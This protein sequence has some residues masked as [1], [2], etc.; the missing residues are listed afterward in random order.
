MPSGWAASWCPFGKDG[1]RLWVRETW[2]K[3]GEVGDEDEYRADNPDP[4]GA[5]WRSS[6][7]MPRSYCRLILE[8]FGSGIQKLDSV[9]DAEAI[10]EGARHFPDL[11]LHDWHRDPATAPRWS[12]GEPETTGDCMETPAL[13]FANYWNYRFGKGDG[14]PDHEAWC[15]A[16]T[17]RRLEATNA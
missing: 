1:D 5:R 9:T 3:A 7:S 11:P 14:W 12:M 17:V 6:T 8:V 4:L 10:A 2:A 13:A 16:M 15:W